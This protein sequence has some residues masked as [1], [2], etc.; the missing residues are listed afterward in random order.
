MRNRI[1]D[2][3]KCDHPLGWLA[4]IEWMVT[5]SYPVFVCN[6]DQI[7]MNRWKKVYVL[8]LGL[9]S[10]LLTACGADFSGS[11]ILNE[12]KTAQKNRFLDISY[13]KKAY[14]FEGKN[15]VKVYDQ[16][17]NQYDQVKYKKADLPEDVPLADIT[18]LIRFAEG[19]TDV[20]IFQLDD[21][22]EI[23][24]KTSR[25]YLKCYYQPWD[26]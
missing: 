3:W 1:G 8:F 20:E 12:T 19:W 9:G 26:K 6:L 13:C 5:L 15:Q 23:A 17:L 22:L 2:K 7:K 25:D 21:E 10:L 18:Y 16:S 14:E 4:F 24:M 11:W